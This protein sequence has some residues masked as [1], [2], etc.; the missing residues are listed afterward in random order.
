MTNNRPLTRRSERKMIA[1]VCGGLADHFGWD[2]NVVRIVA[3]VALVV[4]F[5]S[6]FIAYVVAWFLMPKAPR[7]DPWVSATGATPPAPP[8]PS[9]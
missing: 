9:A 1:G 3:V 6:V 2:A 4:G 5:G 8:A 7:T